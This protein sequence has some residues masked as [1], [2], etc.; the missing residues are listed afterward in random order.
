MADVALWP[1]L[2]AVTVVVPADT[3]ATTPFPSTV[4]TPGVLDD[5]AMARPVSTLL[6]ASLRRAVIG[7]ECPT[8]RLALAGE[9]V[10]DATGE[11]LTVMIEVALF[12]SLVPV[13]VAV[14]G[15]VPVTTPVEETVA[16][17]GESDCHVTTLP[18]R[19]FPSAS[20]VTAVSVVV[21]PT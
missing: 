19:T 4:A 6:S 15:P 1:S 8:R 3:A 11:R 10:I 17:P 13:I 16:T 5:Q 12:P 21:L 2:V 14:P 9:S 20:F 7:T 18:V